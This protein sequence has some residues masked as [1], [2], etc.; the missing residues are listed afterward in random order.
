MRNNNQKVIRKLSDRSLRKN[1]MSNV[2]VLV[3]I[4][5][6]SLLFTTLFSLGS[7]L[8]QITEEQTMRQVG[9]RGH[10][11]LKNVT[12]EQ[13]E[14][15]TAHPMVKE[16]SYNIFLGAAT[17]PELV[18]RSTEIRYT[19]AKDLGYGFV[20][21][22]EGRLPEKEDE[23]LVDTAVM[24]LLGV[25]HELGA[26]LTLKYSFLDK[27][28]ENT[29]T[30]CGWYVTDMIAG[31]SEVYISR[32]YLDKITEGYTEEDFVKGYEE[33]GIGAGLIQG[34]LMF[35]NSQNI[36]GRVQTI[37]A[38]SGY[39][40]EEIEYGI[41]WAYFSEAGQDVDAFSSIVLVIAFLVIMLTGYLIIYNIFRI[42]IA[43]DIRFYG[44]IK[45]IGATKKQIR[46]LVL[47]QAVLLSVMGIPIGLILGYGIGNLAMPLFLSAM[48]TISTA[49]FHLKANPYIFIFSAVFTLVTIF[50][51]CR[52]P[53][54]IA[55]SVSPIEAAK[56]SETNT[57]KKKKKHGVH[58]A[59]IY[60]MAFSNIKRQ[61]KRTVITILSLSL[62]IVLLTE[63]N[64][65]TKSFS[66][67]QYLESMLTGDFMISSISLTN[68]H[69]DYDMKLPEDYYHAVSSQEG[70]EKSARMYTTKQRANHTLSEAA[71]K[72]YQELYEQGMIQT[73]AGKPYSREEE[74]QKVI[75]D[76]EPIVETRYS[77]DEA[78]LSKLK[79]VEGTFDPEKF[80]TGNYV[81]LALY[82]NREETYYQPG[83]KI[84]LQY[85][86]SDSKE[87]IKYY[88]NQQL[89]RYIWTNDRIKEYE[90]MAIVD[91]PSSM[92]VRRYS[93]DCLTTVLPLEEFLSQ[94]GEDAYC[95]TASFWVEDEKESA[96]LNYLKDYTTK[97]DPNTDYE[98]KETLRQE[99]TSMTSAISIVGR[100]LSFIIGLIGL[101]NF[102]NT[103]LT[104]VI[105][106][107]RELTM[108]QSIGLTNRQLRRMLV[109][110]G[111]YYIL[112]TAFISLLVGSALSLSVIK[113]LGNV[114]AYFNYQFT[115]LPYITVLPIFFAFGMLVPGIAYKKVNK[116]SIVARLRE[117][118]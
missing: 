24:D 45:T 27:V 98:S 118:E 6:T 16:H 37:I 97:V 62:S 83:D 85:H 13:Y 31:A 59:R 68:Y 55:G 105:T 28:V 104:N 22:K 106:R 108:L 44:L 84:E 40:P 48:N 77:F 82:P 116:L 25:P 60:A 5:L 67:D 49:G 94:Q 42:S 19:E 79:I 112:L 26:Q 113:A 95:F 102:I 76:N 86:T 14:K 34:T 23:I 50:I 52:R 72:K 2:L 103:M 38:E 11:G 117:T 63:V 57:I 73:D 43:G 61:G 7:G 93:P 12:W 29:F 36:E 33:N 96:F 4:V 75:R 91:L 66:M 46:Y 39:A 81:L 20:S 1:R 64:T 92:T 58:G 56:Y 9:T 111:C 87:V 54:K 35:A 115:I 90:V 21:L 101:L 10:A 3:A 32:E 80:K 18:K 114:V 107:K 99:L 53:G 70:I 65:F 110:E 100:V 74:V 69:V 41:N 78:L 51:S 8:I 15:I 30:V 47:R 71:R 89:A 17:N 88:N 109:Y